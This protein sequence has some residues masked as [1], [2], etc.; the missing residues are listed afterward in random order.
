MAQIA[1]FFLLPN[2]TKTGVDATRLSWKEQVEA[3]DLTG[4]LLI[5]PAMAT[6]FTA[7]NWAGITYSWSNYR[8]VTLLVVSGVLGVCFVVS[9]I[10]RGDK[11]VIPPRIAKIRNVYAGSVFIATSMSSLAV[12]EYYAPT[13]FQAVL[14]YSPARAGYMMTPCLIGTLVGVFSQGIG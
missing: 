14:G 13:Y 9:Q 8:I 4:T 10:V 5:I 11:A 2:V 1:L 3:L 12:L 7:L 6:L